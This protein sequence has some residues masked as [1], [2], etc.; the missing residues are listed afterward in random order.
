MTASIRRPLFEASPVNPSSVTGE[1][2]DNIADELADELVD[3]LAN[4]PAEPD[5][6]L[7]VVVDLVEG[8]LPSTADTRTHIQEA[9]LLTQRGS[10]YLLE[11]DDADAF[12][13]PVRSR[14]QHSL[15][16]EQRLE[17]ENAVRRHRRRYGLR[18]LV[19]GLLTGSLASGLILLPFVGDDATSPPGAEV[20]RS[21]A[22]A[23]SRGRV[24]SNTTFDSGLEGWKTW[25]SN[26]RVSASNGVLRIDTPSSSTGS[27]TASVQLDSI[28]PGNIHALEIEVL[29]PS[30]V[31][32]DVLQ[33]NEKWESL[34]TIALPPITVP[35]ADTDMDQG[36]PIATVTTSNDGGATYRWMFGV[37]PQTRHITVGL[38]SGKRFDVDAVRLS[39]IGQPPTAGA[40][41][42]QDPRVLSEQW[43]LTWSDEFDQPGLDR[44]KWVPTT[45]MIDLNDELQCYADA[46]ETVAVTNGSLAL[47]AIRSPAMCA[48]G[49]PTDGQPAPQVEREF[50]SAMI[51]TKG[52]FSLR[53]GKIVVKARFPQGSGIWPSIWMLPEGQS[54]ASE[55]TDTSAAGPAEIAI[56]ET[57]RLGRR[58]FG[59]LHFDATAASDG[60]GSRTGST[61]IPGGASAF[62]EYGLEWTEN[63]LR[64]TLDGDVFFE[65]GGGNDPWV[66]PAGG[67]WPAPLDEPFYLII[68]LAI[69]GAWS[70]TPDA[71]TVFPATTEVDWIRVYRVKDAKR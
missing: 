54:S 38:A 32:V 57:D 52:R 70:G 60:R 51:T 7:T 35:P 8:E 19:A 18:C 9:G 41:L 62:H 55:Q 48:T 2:A 10:F 44:G 22:I 39:D 65:T 42:Q 25:W 11:D 1:I 6:D 64:W 27:A 53:Q 61:E 13:T 15:I 43:A 59:S 40:P 58:T 20:A 66:P 67:A 49:V 31:T 68:N 17:R 63:T 12:D 30:P 36:N 24:L 29:D 45:G 46:P 21:S 47:T 71:E 14:Q 5:A 23:P 37:D 3:E 33:F 16:V 4:E 50:R 56:A 28:E 26:G 34:R 69:G